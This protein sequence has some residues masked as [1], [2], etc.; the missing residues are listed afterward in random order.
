MVLLGPGVASYQPR[1]GGGGGGVGQG[2]GGGQE[3]GM[4]KRTMLEKHW[5]PQAGRTSHGHELDGGS[6][7]C[8][9]TINR[10]DLSNMMKALHMLWELIL[11][12]ED[13]STVGDNCIVTGWKVT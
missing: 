6:A 3:H 7:L 1:K 5:S 11:C 9:H 4:K 10:L 8:C 13:V 2:V 12:S